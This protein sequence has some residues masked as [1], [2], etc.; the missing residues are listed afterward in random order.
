MTKQFNPRIRTQFTREEIPS[1]YEIEKECFS[2]I[3][4]WSKTE[5]A[6]QLTKCNVWIM[7]DEFP[8]EPFEDERGVLLMGAN[9]V[10]GFLVAKIDRGQAYILTVEV[11]EKYRGRGYGASLVKE[12]ERV[13][14]ARGFKTIRLEVY[15]E[16]PAQLMY[17]KL[18]Y[19]VNGFKKDYYEKGKSAVAMAKTL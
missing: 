8:N 11:P 4:R 7:E 6:S 17:F 15:T 18:G 2:P 14:K 16:N 1:L 9:H 13:Y 12:C 19:R 3:F 5:F 10:V